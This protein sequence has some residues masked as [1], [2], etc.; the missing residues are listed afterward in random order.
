MW[1]DPF[2]YCLLFLRSRIFRKIFIL[3]LL[4]IYKYFFNTRSATALSIVISSV[5]LTESDRFKYK[6]TIILTPLSFNPTL[7]K[8]SI[9]FFSWFSLPKILWYELKFAFMVQFMSQYRWS[10]TWMLYMVSLVAIAFS[11]LTKL[12]LAL[13]IL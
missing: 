6:F 13:F 2:A 3:E 1:L 11:K 12:M 5:D 10:N 4:W 7:L 9:N 8:I